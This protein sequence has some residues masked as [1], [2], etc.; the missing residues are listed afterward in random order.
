M[1]MSD[2]ILFA[3]APNQRYAA[4]IS[5]DGGILHMNRL[6]I[7]SSLNGSVFDT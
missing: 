1:A 3:R 4:K 7:C 6:K 5:P 2:E